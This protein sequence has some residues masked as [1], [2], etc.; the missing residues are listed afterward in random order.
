MDTTLG[1]RNASEKIVACMNKVMAGDSREADAM[2]SQ[3]KPFL[4]LFDA[5]KSEHQAA[6]DN[7]EA[8]ERVLDGTSTG[9]AT[10]CKTSP[11]V[12][13]GTEDTT[14]CEGKIYAEVAAAR[15]FLE[16]SSPWFKVYSKIIQNS[17]WYPKY[18]ALLTS[19]LK[20]CQLNHQ[21]R[22]EAIPSAP[23]AV[24]TTAPT[25]VPTA[26]GAAEEPYTSS[27]SSATEERPSYTSSPTP[28]PTSSPTEEPK[29]EM[30]D[31]IKKG[32]RALDEAKDKRQAEVAEKAVK[33]SF[34]KQGIPGSTNAEKV[35][36]AKHTLGQT[37]QWAEE[38][39]RY[40]G[41]ALDAARGYRKGDIA[42]ALQH[43]RSTEEI[44]GAMFA[45]ELAT[46]K[47][48]Q[49]SQ[50]EEDHDKE[51]LILLAKPMK[52]AQEAAH[53]A[54]L[55][56][57]HAQRALATT[58]GTEAR[59]QAKQQLTNAQEAVREAHDILQRELTKKKALL[60]G[61]IRKVD[62][63]LVA[64]AELHNLA[65]V[66]YEEAQKV[67]LL[68]IEALSSARACQEA[69]LKAKVAEAKAT[70]LEKGSKQVQKERLAKGREKAQSDKVVQWEKEAQEFDRQAL[71]AG[72]NARDLMRKAAEA[73]RIAALKM[74]AL[75]ELRADLY[76]EEHPS[77]NGE[78]A[79]GKAVYREA[80]AAM[81][82][83]RASTIE[84]AAMVGRAKMHPLMVEEAIRIRV[85]HAKVSE[86]KAAQDSA[87]P[88]DALLR[89]WRREKGM[90]KAY[91]KKYYAR[92]WR[93]A[94]AKH[95]A[96]ERKVDGELPPAVTFMN[97]EAARVG[98]THDDHDHGTRFKDRLSILLG[99]R[100]AKGAG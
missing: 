64:Q 76:K 61:E 69:H 50:Q 98:T 92:K 17:V 73:G 37:R 99:G 10:F 49:R 100:R 5:L 18:E 35:A 52:L 1:A 13:K 53:D 90:W 47:S 12:R 93:A 97:V 27:Y 25:A 39:I 54:G 45:V 41:T 14:V 95:D 68:V 2:R 84:D 9:A 89:Q 16:A 67:L 62:A 3:D 11:A 91:Y 74:V 15:K 77:M 60:Q 81:V 85:K 87:L 51:K 46:K 19:R 56:V 6:Y 79:T 30:D 38:T 7:F 75:V 59:A 82:A 70:S 55:S 83:I 43:R 36:W 94:K 31:A 4:E 8:Q 33:A 57:S 96:L 63:R 20:Q 42:A 26:T 48:A 80:A 32:K 40:I 21:V 88:S 23:T 29:S 78:G 44:R 71:D 34:K 22:V 65:A 58:K 66:T 24:P 28:A 86:L 72:I